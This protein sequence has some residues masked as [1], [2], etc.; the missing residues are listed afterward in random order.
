MNLA[1]ETGT[2]VCDFD[3]MTG[4]VV[5]ED[6]EL[7]PAEQGAEYSLMMWTLFERAFERSRSHGAEID[8]S[9]SLLDFCREQV[10]KMVPETDQD[11][12]K[13]RRIL[14]QMCELWGNYVGSPVER[15]SLKFFWLE[16][17]IEGGML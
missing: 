12:E 8:P 10:M 1:R 13:K 3:P 15:Q 17:T 2:A 4:G 11:F 9:A 6:G 7:L 5:D 16:E 14:L